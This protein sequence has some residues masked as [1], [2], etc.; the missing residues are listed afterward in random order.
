MNLNV[1][2]LLEWLIRR[3][4]ILEF[5][6]ETLIISL[7]PYSLTPLFKRVTSISFMQNSSF[8]FL[9]GSN[10]V[11]K[12]LIVKQCLADSSVL[13]KILEF[14]KNGGNKTFMS[15]QTSIL[16]E[17]V[18][19]GL[20]SNKLRLI[21]PYLIDGLKGDV[22]VRAS[23]QI[24]FVVITKLVCIELNVLSPFIDS[25]IFGLNS[26]NFNDTLLFILSIFQNQVESLVDYSFTTHSVQT[27]IEFP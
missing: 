23:S 16:V 26:D 6:F 10:T 18:S 1:E 2:Y 12:S 3:Y 7:L 9:V 21:L 20:D 8:D 14:G 27:L 15:F 5:N 25:V 11:D 19:K 17:Y 4:D 24:V 22:D 13:Q